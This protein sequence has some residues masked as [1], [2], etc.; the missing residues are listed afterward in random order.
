MIFN[1]I[2][3]DF[4]TN[5]D[6]QLAFWKNTFTNEAGTF[7]IP[8]MSGAGGSNVFSM[9][10]GIV[11]IALGYNSYEFS[12]TCTQQLTFVEAANKFVVILFR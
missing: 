8:T 12:W 6:Y 2:K 5:S 4:F 1:D 3:Q 9:P 10:N 7:Y 11:G